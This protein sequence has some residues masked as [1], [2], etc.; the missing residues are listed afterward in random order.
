M[1]MKFFIYLF[2]VV[3]FTGCKNNTVQISGTIVNPVSG[4]YIF[5]DELKSNELITIDSVKVSEKGTFSFKKEIT[6]P[7]FYLLKSQENNFLTMLISPGEKLN[8]KSYH[9][10][11]NY[12]IAVSGSKGTELMA[13]YN[14]TLRNTIN[15]LKG[16]EAIYQKNINNPNLS[17]V[18]ESLDSTANIYL[19]EINLY[20]KS[21]I[22][23]NIN[24]LVSLVALYQQVAPRVY[25]LNPSNDIK[26]FLK[27][28]SALSSLY[29]QYE[30]VTALHEQVQKLV[31]G[32]NGN[33]G[34]N[35]EYGEGSVAPEI[36]LPTPAGDTVKLS[37]TKGSV[38]LL[39]FWASWCAPCRK[40]SPNL[41]KAYDLYHKKGFNIYQVSLDKTKEAWM[42]GI[43]D[44][45]LGK[46][47]H[48]SDIQYWNSIVVPLYKI[49]SIPN[50]YLLDKE[51]RIITT[52]LRGDQLQKKLAE[53]FKK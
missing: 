47:I 35:P 17:V 21:Y 9:D 19:N 40:E 37:S 39:D 48:V 38:V 22:D 53:I 20:T 30:P 36:S 3:A 26:Y 43:Q 44:D 45:N 1:N 25:V 33:T 29:P 32:I 50:N 46:W 2:A 27:V 7:A 11:L 8:V 13:E 4:E 24:S 5:L 14:I 52:N 18:M 51:G 12:P 42:K 31:A 10:S 23:E 15:K 49:E 41:V 6:Q 34:T 16:L 28:D